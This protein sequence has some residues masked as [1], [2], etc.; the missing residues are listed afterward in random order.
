[1]GWYEEL[2]NG[3]GNGRRPDH[4]EI[5]RHFEALSSQIF[6]AIGVP[7]DKWIAQDVDDVEDLGLGINGLISGSKSIVEKDDD[8]WCCNYKMILP[9]NRYI[10]VEMHVQLIGGSKLLT[11][12]ADVRLL[13]EQP[14][15]EFVATVKTSV[16]KKVRAV[17]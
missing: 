9:S 8:N 14:F 10:L 11:H 4:A 1:M 3:V 13:R 2:G 17:G 16:E 15:D 5:K 12:F 7:S 6:G